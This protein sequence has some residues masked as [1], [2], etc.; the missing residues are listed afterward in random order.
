MTRR[1]KVLA[2]TLLILLVGMGG[3]ASFYFFIY[4]PLATAEAQYASAQEQLSKKRGELSQEEAQ[5][6]GVM[7]VNPRLSQWQK[8][9]LPPRDPEGKK[10]GLSPEVQKRNHLARMQ[11]EYERYL[12]ELMRSSGFRADSIAVSHTQPDTKT[13]LNTPKGKEP[14]YERLAFGAAGKGTKDALVKMLA[15]FHKEPLLHQVRKLAVAVA[16]PA[17]GGPRRGGPPVTEGLLDVNLTVEALL[18]NGAEERASLKPAPL[19]YPPRVLA[20][21]GRNYQML[22]KRNM[23]AGYTPPRAEA[24]ARVTEDRADVLRF[25]KLTTLYYNPDRDRWEAS[26]YDQA[27]GPRRVEEQDEDGNTVKKVFWERQLNTRL[28]NELKVPDRYGNTVLDAKVVHIDERQLVFKVD[29]SYFRLRCGDALYPAIEQPLG[30]DDVKE[31]GL[32]D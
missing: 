27:A 11:V 20:E 5:I 7:R 28:L 21:P 8:I 1:E 10:A 26:M 6:K 14:T 16:N 23:F 17:A 18:V 30:E 24:P 2:T 9:S 29:N 19:S 12:R 13:K 15:E 22:A 4:E 32:G 25:I 31:L 3:L